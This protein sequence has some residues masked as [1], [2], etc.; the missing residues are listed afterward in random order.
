MSN[1]S[2]NILKSWHLV[3]FFQPYNIPDNNEAQIKVTANELSLLKEAILPWLDTNAYQKLKVTPN[4]TAYY[5][6]YLNVFDKAEV[7]KISAQCFGEETDTT[8]S[9]EFV[10]RLQ[11]EG[12]TCFAKLT[13]D[14]WGTPNFAEMSV[15]TLPWALGH[16]QRNMLEKL[17]LSEFDARNELLKEVLE[18]IS[19]QLPEHPENPEVKTLNANVII[20][21]INELN[22]WAQFTPE[23]QFVFCLDWYETRG[24]GN[25]SREDKEIAVI[26][27]ESD[28]GESQSDERVM[29]ILNSFYIDDIV[30]LL[31]YLLTY[32]VKLNLKEH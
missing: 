3:E 11:K 21:L 16:L 5:Q 28:E 30:N 27:E 10:E 15:S 2:L 26:D 8:K 14:Q 13:L 1:T 4:K 12:D 7:E 6:L 9:I 24:G 18:R 17:N 29:P 23:S 32:L 31:T 20:T 19:A 22:K 25:N